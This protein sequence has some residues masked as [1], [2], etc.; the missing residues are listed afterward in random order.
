[1]RHVRQAR[2]CSRGA[3]KFFKDFN[4]D[5]NTFIKEGLDEET[6]LATNHGLAKL[7]VDTAH[8]RK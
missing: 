8:G 1:M 7:V 4:L 6:L 2:M 3:R 5:W